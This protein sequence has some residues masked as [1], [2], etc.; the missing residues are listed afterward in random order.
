MGAFYLRNYSEDIEKK[1]AN[2]EFLRSLAHLLLPHVYITSPTTTT[3]STQDYNEVIKV[4]NKL[5]TTGVCVPIL[6]NPQ[7]Q[8]AGA[9]EHT[10]EFWME[11]NLQILSRCNAVFNPNK[12]SATAKLEVVE[13]ERLELQ[14]FTSVSSLKDWVTTLNED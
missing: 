7:P 8:W 4:A 9:Y 1:G 12:R 3:D 2:K 6:P 10:T 14:V 11:Y 13:A 5:Y